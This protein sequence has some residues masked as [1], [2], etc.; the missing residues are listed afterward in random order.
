ML[1]KADGLVTFAKFSVC[2]ITSIHKSLKRLVSIFAFL[3]FAF[4]F[5]SFFSFQFLYVFD[6]FSKF[7]INAYI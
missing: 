2:L 3:T 4:S 1:V 6:V 5:V 7:Y